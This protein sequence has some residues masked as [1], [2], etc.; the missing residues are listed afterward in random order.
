MLYFIRLII[1]DLFGE[2]DDTGILKLAN[3]SDSLTVI[4]YS[5]LPGLSERHVFYQKQ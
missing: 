3:R 2:G 1:Y 4:S 5:S